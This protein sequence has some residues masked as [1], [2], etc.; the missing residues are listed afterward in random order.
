VL[1]AAKPAKMGYQWKVGDGRNIKFW[2]DRWFGSCSL[3]IQYLEVYFLVNEQNK[4]IA[5][6]WDGSSLKMTFRRCFD[7]RL[8]MQWLEI[9]QISQTIILSSIKDSLIWKWEANGLYSVKSMYV[10]ANFGGIKPVDI[11]CVCKIKVS[12]KIH[13][14]SLVTLP[15]QATH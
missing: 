12:P 6:L 8:M 11:H 13:F 4:T 10:V 3:A 7:H 5:D 14:F 1:W 15:Q 2:E 9:Q